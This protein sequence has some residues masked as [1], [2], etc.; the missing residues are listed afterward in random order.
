MITDW[1]SPIGEIG[2]FPGPGFQDHRHRPL[3]H[4]SA[5]PVCSE[6]LGFGIGRDGK[7]EAQDERRPDADSG[8]RRQHH[9]AD[10]T[11]NDAAERDGQ[12]H[13]FRLLVT[14]DANACDGPAGSQTSEVRPSWR[15]TSAWPTASAERH[16][17][18]SAQ[19]PT[20]CAVASAALLGSDASTYVPDPPRQS[21]DPASFRPVAD[22]GWSLDRRTKPYH[23]AR[24]RACSSTAMHTLPFNRQLP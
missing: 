2:P 15:S 21:T 14:H 11:D 18:S 5:P 10:C 20:S 9:G 6:N 4:P 7:E 1:R 23:R 16:Q 19:L 3:G 12:E 17:S 24:A 8:V 13:A 22:H